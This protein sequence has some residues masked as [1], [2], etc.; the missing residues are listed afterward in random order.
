MYVFISLSLSCRTRHQCSRCPKNYA[1]KHGLQQHQKEKHEGRR[2]VCEYCLKTYTQKSSVKT[3]QRN[4]HEREISAMR[5]GAQRRGT[6][7]SLPIIVL[8]EMS[9]SQAAM[10]LYRE[11]QQPSTRNEANSPI[12]NGTENQTALRDDNLMN[13]IKIEDEI[14]DVLHQTPAR[15]APFC[16]KCGTKFNNAD[17]EFC[18][19][20]GTQRQQ[21]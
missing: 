20:S 5:N 6:R 11:Q 21:K 19:I 8:S 16:T 4:V 1:F 9:A 7:S 17:D 18:R 13:T 2:F 15:L 3:H 10:D 14:G 12:S